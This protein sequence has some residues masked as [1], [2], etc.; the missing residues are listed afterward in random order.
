[1]DTLIGYTFGDWINLLRENHWA[2]SRG[3]WGRALA[4]TQ[5]SIFNSFTARKE[6][7]LYGKEIAQVKGV[8]PIFI[9][10]HWRSGTTLLHNLMTRDKR[11]AYPNLFQATHPHIFLIGEEMAKRR[12]SEKGG[13]KRHMDNIRLTFQSPGED[14][15]A[16][17]VLSL[18]SPVLGWVFPKNMTYYD[19]FLTFNSVDD[20]EVDRWLSALD[21]FY[22]KLTLRYNRRLIFKSPTHTGR[23]KCLIHKFPNAQFIHIHRNPYHVFQSTMRLYEKVLPEVTL[24]NFDLQSMENTILN[25]YTTMYDAYFSSKNLI[26]PGNLVEIRFSDLENDKIGQIGRIYDELGLPDFEEFRPELEDYVTT[27]SDYKKNKYPEMSDKLHTKIGQA[28][29]RN[30]EIWGYEI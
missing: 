22:R 30:F 14:E 29:K 16:L 19:R 25:N 21:L 11:F 26:P 27:L 24:Q 12:L 2:V 5:M 9:L 10:G 7:K 18:R 23:I 6:E 28:W 8:D 3:Y 20:G 1:M 17:A 15:P 4:V 13:E